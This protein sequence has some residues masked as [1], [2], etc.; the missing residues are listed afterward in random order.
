[1]KER[2]SIMAN[3][4][5]SKNHHKTTILIV[6]LFH[7]KGLIEET[8]L[9]DHYHILPI[10]ADTASEDMIFY[11]RFLDSWKSNKIISSVIPDMIMRNVEN[12]VST[13]DYLE[14]NPIVHLDIPSL[15]SVERF[16]TGH[17]MVK[18][19]EDI[20]TAT[21]NERKKAKLKP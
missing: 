19:S 20:A 12:L 4:L 11:S 18:M 9:S 14:A 5:I 2:N 7:L 21:A 17:E 16:Y 6:G 15:P 8:S 3:T 1:M 10:C 13:V